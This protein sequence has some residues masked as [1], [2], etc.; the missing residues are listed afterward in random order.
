MT[1]LHIHNE[2]LYPYDDRCPFPGCMPGENEYDNP[3]IVLGEE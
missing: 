3:N 2:T 1:Y